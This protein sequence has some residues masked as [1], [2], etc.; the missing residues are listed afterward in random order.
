MR[1]YGFDRVS[2]ACRRK[3]PM[4]ARQGLLVEIDSPENKEDN[5][6]GNR[7][8][9]DTDWPKNGRKKG[10][11]H[12]WWSGVAGGDRGHSGAHRWYLNEDLDEGNLS[13]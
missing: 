8:N 11:N 5:G 4:V 9:P 1:V 13:E 12:Y 2:G 3:T 6:G 7:R 10:Q